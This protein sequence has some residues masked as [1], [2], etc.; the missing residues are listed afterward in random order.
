[1]KNHASKSLMAARVHFIGIGGIGMCGLAELLHNMGSTVTGSDL[2]DNTQIHRLRELGIKVSIGQAAENVHGAEVVVYSSAVK[3]TNAEYAEARRLK[4]PLI[5]RAES[6]AEIMRLKRGIAVGGSHGKTTT[7]SMIAA[8]FLEAQANPTIVVGGRLDLIKSTAVLGSGEWMIAEADESDGSFSRLSP[9]IALVTNID[10]DHLDHYGTFEHLKKA[11]SDF[12]SRV[13]FYGAAIV[14]WDDPVIRETFAPFGKRLVRYGFSQEADLRIEG[15]KSQYKV[16]LDRKLLGEFRLHV[17]GR[18]NALNAAA[19]LATALEA[20]I[21][22]ATAV[23]GLD[24]FN[25]VDR[26]FQHKGKV[27]GVDVFDDYGHHPTEVDAVLKAFRERYGDRRLIVAFQPH[28]YSRTKLCWDQFQT[29]FGL[30]DRVFITDIYAAGEDPI[31]NID[32]TSMIQGVKSQSQQ[33]VPREGISLIESKSGLTPVLKQTAAM[34]AEVLTSENSSEAD[35]PALF[36]LGAGD[37]WKLSSEVLAA[38]AD[39]YETCGIA[40]PIKKVLKS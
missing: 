30:A 27:H 2:A 6:L 39:E 17:P 35:A 20:G 29:C 10:N 37:I 33:H 31:P 8:I 24:R 14:C 25:G 19:A 12:A 11:F 9:E 36:T 18:H 1:M 26:R 23:R 40:R 34:L 22:F 13:P 38:L 15:E 7:T 32:S 5:P 16:F 21:E 3:P 4:I 28:R